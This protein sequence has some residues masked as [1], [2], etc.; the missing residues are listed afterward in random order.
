MS[1]RKLVLSAIVF[2]NSFLRYGETHLFRKRLHVK[3]SS[4]LSARGQPVILRLQPPNGIHI[5]PMLSSVWR[6]AISQIRRQL[7]N[8]PSEENTNGGLL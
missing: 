6:Q 1:G 4:S 3:L 5:G 2:A 7:G 8:A